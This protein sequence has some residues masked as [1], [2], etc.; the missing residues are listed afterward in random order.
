M[1][2]EFKPVE[3]EYW[4]DG[5]RYPSVT[6]ILSGLGLLPDYSKLDPFYRERGTAVHACIKMHL[7]GEE[8]DW[9][10]E[11]VDEVRPRFDRFLWFE[12]EYELESI[13]V[14][15][16]MSS[17]FGFA[18]T[19][20]LLAFSKKLEKVVLPDWKGD[21][22]APG[23]DLQ[24]EGYAQL[25]SETGDG[26][27]GSTYSNGDIFTCPAYIVTL[28]GNGPRPGIHP[29]N[30]SIHN[31]ELFLAAVAVYNWRTKNVRVK[32]GS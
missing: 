1:A 15:E 32:N 6:Q 27:Y 5:V 18:G 14:E 2:L 10:F 29:V 12:E 8:I 28:G 17:R 3:H 4:V 20:D 23:Q 31:R 25:I 16:P 11:G 30:R 9:D 26:S 21:A 19:P 13:V 22:R 24:I 7:L